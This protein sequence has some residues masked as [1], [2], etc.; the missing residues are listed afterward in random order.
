MLVRNKR[1]FETIITRAPYGVPIPWHKIKNADARPA[2]GPGLC[3]LQEPGHFGLN[4]EFARINNRTSVGAVLLMVME[5][6][7]TRPPAR[8]RL[9]SRGDKHAN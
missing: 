5:K 8:E 4:G 9:M 3:T 7:G 6:K 2:W 1:L